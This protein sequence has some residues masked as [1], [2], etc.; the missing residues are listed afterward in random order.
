MR[1]E[2][3]LSPSIRYVRLDD[4]QGLLSFPGWGQGTYIEG[5]D[6]DLVKRLLP[7]LH[8]GTTY[9]ELIDTLD[10]PDH[11][12]EALLQRLQKA[13]AFRVNRPISPRVTECDATVAV[14]S[15][16][17][18][19]DFELPMPVER[20][21]D[22][23]SLATIDID[24]V[25]TVTAE[26]RPSFQRTVADHATVPWVP[27][28]VVGS[29]L[30]LGPVFVPSAT[31]C[32]NCYEQRLLASVVDRSVTWAEIE[33]R[34]AI[35]LGYPPSTIAALTSFGLLF[36][37]DVLTSANVAGNFVRLDPVD[38]EAM[39]TTVQATPGCTACEMS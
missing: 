12:I 4:D 32:Y 36:T 34:A 22:P 16:D 3:R 1:Q 11:Q 39:A 10:L 13:G 25:L 29:K 17:Q 20:I 14:L 18:H 30:W 35:N 37:V 24:A 7:L 15:A 5:D 9:E 6:C 2:Y 19:L 27:A 23:E 21:D 38:G 8:D 26:E 33:L 28:R 31:P